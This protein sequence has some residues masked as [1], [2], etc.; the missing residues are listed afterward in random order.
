MI[1]TI[2]LTGGSGFIG[3]TLRARLA[4][5]PWRIRGLTR[6]QAEVDGDLALGDLLEPDS[7]RDRLRGADAVVH[8]AASTGR[9]PE[10]DQ[11]RTNVEG[12]RALLA[13]CRDA[14]VDRILHV[15]T[16]AAGY[17]DKRHYSYAQSKLAAEALVR[18]SGLGFTILRPTIV[19]GTDSPIGQTLGRIAGL[20]LIPLPQGERPVMVQPVDVSDV[21]RGV[22]IVLAERHFQG[23]VLDLGGAD[24]ETFADFLNAVRRATRGAPA[25]IVRVPLGPIHALLAATEGVAGRWQPVTA[26]PMALFANE[27][28]AAD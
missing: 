27:S 18:D 1:Q 26:G 13:A 28:V 17:S 6:H 21:A 11:W 24:P 14:A 20:P 22:E 19:L 12:T 2:F 7:Y 9:S 8:L 3:R 16:I 23:E 5:G 15:S 10:A 4:G 25:R